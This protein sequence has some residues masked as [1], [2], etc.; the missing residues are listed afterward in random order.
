MIELDFY[1]SFSMELRSFEIP[2]VALLNSANWA[3][4][5]PIVSTL[6]R[7][8]YTNATGNIMWLRVSPIHVLTFLLEKTAGRY[9]QFWAE[10]V[11]GD[12]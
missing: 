1:I 10:V 6:H 4:G 11:G 5:G 12:T 9:I 7:N 8:Q 3:T 2:Y